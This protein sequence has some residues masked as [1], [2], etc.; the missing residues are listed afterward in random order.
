MQSE[1]LY[2]ALLTAGSALVAL[3]TTTVGT[4]L[5]TGVV[6]IGVGLVLFGA[7]RYLHVKA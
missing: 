4:D 7:Y 1:T 6:E 5:W 3:G 2:T